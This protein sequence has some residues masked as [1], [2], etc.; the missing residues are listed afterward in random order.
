VPSIDYYQR[1]IDI[2][3][4]RALQGGHHDAVKYK[5]DFSFVSV[6]FSVLSR[7]GID[8]TD[9]NRCLKSRTLG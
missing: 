2:V 1:I 4:I 3:E 6:N 5:T 8:V 9:M 7:S